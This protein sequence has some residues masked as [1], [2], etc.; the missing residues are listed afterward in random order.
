[1]KFRKKP[2]HVDAVRVTK[3]MAW[4]YLVKKEKSV[5]PVGCLMARGTW[6]EANGTV[7]EFCVGMDTSNGNRAYARLGDWILID[8]AGVPYPCTDEVFQ[9]S[10]APVDDDARVVARPDLLRQVLEAHDSCDQ[11][12]IIEAMDAVRDA[13]YPAIASASNEREQL[14]EETA[15]CGGLIAQVT[16]LR[17]DINRLGEALLSLAE[18]A[19]VLDRQSNPNLGPQGDCWDAPA[20]LAKV[21][22]ISAVIYRNRAYA[23]VERRHYMD[24]AHYRVNHFVSALRVCSPEADV[25]SHL[26]GACPLRLADLEAVV[27]ESA[28]LFTGD[29]PKIA[30]H[31]FTFTPPM[32]CHCKRVID[33]KIGQQGHGQGGTGEDFRWWH[34]PT[35]PPVEQS[36]VARR[37]ETT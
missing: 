27:R 32:C 1:M 16:V 10:Y 35:C 29:A 7:D 15:R 6:H 21:H 2:V 26:A 25:I 22:E 20:L 17:E 19:G 23:P 30:R 8:T 37:G 12:R 14:A 31:E 36:G 4:A 3:E 24:S 33:F 9:A 5:L 13:V 18:D 11:T 28:P 34:Y